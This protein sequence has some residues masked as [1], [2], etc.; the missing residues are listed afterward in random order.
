VFVRADIVEVKV[1][2]AKGDLYSV[3]GG[4]MGFY[5]TWP[6]NVYCLLVNKSLRGLF[7]IS[8]SVN[9]RRFLSSGI[10]LKFTACH[11]LIKSYQFVFIMSSVDAEYK[12][13]RP[14]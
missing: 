1:D 8:L 2:Q 6:C 9:I 7:A 5:P 10:K 4:K 11:S 13:V 12:H 3:S 14:C